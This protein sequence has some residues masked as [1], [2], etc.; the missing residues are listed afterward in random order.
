LSR[1]HKHPRSF[2]VKNVQLCSQVI[3][4]QRATPALHQVASAFMRRP[5]GL[6]PETPHSG[7][8]SLIGPGEAR[9]RQ[10][11]GGK[12]GLGIQLQ[13]PCEATKLLLRATESECKQSKTRVCLRSR[14]STQTRQCPAAAWVA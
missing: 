9:S 5:L 14:G 2:K 6:I 1:C 12:R 11:E 10:G 4:F 13:S 3:E 7:S 8:T